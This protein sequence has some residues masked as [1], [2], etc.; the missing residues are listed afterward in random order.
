MENIESIVARQPF[1]NGLKPEHLHTLNACATFASFDK[2]D[3][4]F[5]EGATADHFYLVQ[6]GHV[7]L[8]ASAPDRGFKTVQT[9]GPGD[10]LG[11]SW[12][13]EPWHWNFT[14]RAVEAGELVSFDARRLRERIEANHDL[15]YELLTRFAK[16]ML[17][18]LQA[19]RMQLLGLTKKNDE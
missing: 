14:A 5:R 8:E 13:F 11:W 17:Q 12:L 7:K 4:I 1:L 18:R 6:S 19:T 10:A 3:V 15:G 16:V 9:I 2:G